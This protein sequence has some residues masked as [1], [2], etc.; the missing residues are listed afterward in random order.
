MK[1]ILSFEDEVEQQH[2]LLVDD[3]IVEQA[4]STADGIPAD[5]LEKLDAIDQ[6]LEAFGTLCHIADVVASN[7]SFDPA[8][9]AVARIA[10]EAIKKPLGIFD[11]EAIVAVESFTSTGISIEGFTDTLKT[12]WQAIV[13]TFEAIRKAIMSAIRGSKAKAHA[14]AVEK[15]VGDIE[16]LKAEAKKENKEVV[17]EPAPE[18][19][20]LR[21]RHAAKHFA[22]LDES[23]VLKPLVLVQHAHTLNKSLSGL[24]TLSSDMEKSSTGM[25]RFIDNL[26]NKVLTGKNRAAL[27]KEATTEAKAAMNEY[28]HGI[29]TTFTDGGDLKKYAQV[30]LEK[31]TI[32]FNRVTPGSIAHLPGMSRGI[33]IFA[34]YT[35]GE[36]MQD[37][38]YRFFISP[39]AEVNADNVKVDFN[40]VAEFD[41]YCASVHTA[42][43][44]YIRINRDY[45]TRCNRIFSIQDETLKKMDKHLMNLQRD[46]E[47]LRVYIASCREIARVSSV[48]MHALN[49]FMLVAERSL[50]D[51]SSLL[52]AMLPLFKA[53]A[54]ESQ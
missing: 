29:K 12:I 40:S 20:L 11:H 8:S 49:A 42:F 44:D 6:G 43:E 18:H 53:E 17:I 1:T 13:R 35:A 41:L 27:G 16:D 3:G 37:L 36:T 32:P 48:A 22:F 7:E 23:Q 25:R 51:H 50:Y 39:E 54:T 46:Q 47:S 52:R 14:A 30:L 15:V 33:V 4:I 9:I 28:F 45:E 19:I 10:M 2:P 26:D 31:N 38:Q 24:D 5:V 21:I 34:F